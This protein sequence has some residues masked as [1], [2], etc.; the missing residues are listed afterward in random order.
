DRDL[1]VLVEGDGDA[2][3][4]LRPGRVVVEDEQAAGGGG[5]HGS[6]LPGDEWRDGRGP[7]R[8]R[9]P[10]PTVSGAGHAAVT[11]TTADSAKPS[12]EIVVPMTDQVLM[13]V[14]VSKPQNLTNSQTSV[15]VTFYHANVAAPIS[16]TAEETAT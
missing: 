4:A 1:R 8:T 16:I 5:G 7:M 2:R 6:L 12:S 9:A 15:T 10:A 3:D 14:T 11:N 13:V